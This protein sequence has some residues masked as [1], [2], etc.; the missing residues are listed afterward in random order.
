MDITLTQQIKTKALELGF[1]KVGVSPAV[2]PPRTAYLTEWLAKGNHGQMYWLARAP[3][4]RMD[5]RRVVPGARSVISLATHYYTEGPPAQAGGGAGVISRYAWGSDYHLLIESRLRRLYEYM[6]T[7]DPGIEG[8]YYVDTGPVMEK[9]LAQQG[10]VGWI[11]KHTNLITPEYGSWV[12]LSEIIVTAPLAYDPP[13]VDQCG[14]CRLCIDACPTQAITAPYVLDARRCISYLTIELRSDIPGP[15]RPLVDQHLFGCDICQDVC[16]WNAQPA[17]SGDPAFQPRPGNAPVDLAG[18]TVGGEA[19]FREHFQG[20]AVKR[21]KW[22]GFLRNLL[23]AM[24]NSRQPFFIP[25]LQRFLDHADDTIRSHAAWA[26]QR[27]RQPS[28]KRMER[29]N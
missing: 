1:Q 11:G 17:V 6:R 16:P 12:F 15:L 7:L 10:G 13:A 9:A 26:V 18:M 24:G 14:H 5:P 20:S 23:V 29:E 19:R 4:R 27:L 25:L 8:R 3:E 22:L 2:P 28:A 21:A